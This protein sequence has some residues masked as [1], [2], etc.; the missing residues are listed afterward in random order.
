MAEV[1]VVGVPDAKWDE[2]PLAMIVAKPNKTVN[3]DDVKAHLSQFV[4]SGHINK[5]AIP[6]EIQ[7][8]DEIPKTSVGKINK[9]VIRQQHG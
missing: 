6:S 3:A 1:A 2:R 4:E 5:W 8:V 7:V 9:K